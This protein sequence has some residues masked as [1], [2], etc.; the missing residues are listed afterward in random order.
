MALLLHSAAASETETESLTMNDMTSQSCVYLYNEF[1]EPLFAGEDSVAH[2]SGKRRYV[3]T[4]IN[5]STDPLDHNKLWQ[6]QKLADRKYLILNI[7]YA[8]YLYCPDGGHEFSTNERKI[9]TWWDSKSVDDDA[10]WN[11][12]KAEGSNNRYYIRNNHY[13]HFL[14]SR[15]GLLHQV[16]PGYRYAVGILQNNISAHNATW[17]IIPCTEKDKEKSITWNNN[18]SLNGIYKGTIKKISFQINIE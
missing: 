11:I 5:S 7:F 9:F 6:I 13:G 12:Y 3:F 16:L 15:N 1:N 17:K 18:I 10:D 2:E 14:A 4:K 8:E